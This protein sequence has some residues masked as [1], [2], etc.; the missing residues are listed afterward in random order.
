MAVAVMMMRITMSVDPPDTSVSLNE[1]TH[2]ITDQLHL[3]QKMMDGELQRWRNGDNQ[4]DDVDA[5]DKTNATRTAEKGGRG[6]N[7]KRIH[8]E[9]RV[10]LSSRGLVEEMV[11]LADYA[12]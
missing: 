6:G 5:A 8:L 10:R 7:G 12:S 11:P 1:N 4:R 3:S 9:H 2:S